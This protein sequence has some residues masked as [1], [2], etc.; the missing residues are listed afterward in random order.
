[1]AHDYARVPVD[2]NRQGWGV[3]AFIVLLAVAAAFGAWTIHE[4]TYQHPRAPITMPHTAL[5]APTL[6]VG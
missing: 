3:A 2:N 4:R 1:M 5:P 6:H